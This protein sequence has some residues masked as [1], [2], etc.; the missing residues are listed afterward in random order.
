MRNILL[1]AACLAVLIGSAHATGS[2][3]NSNGPTDIDITL[4]GGDNKATNTTTTTVYGDTNKLTSDVDVNNKTNIDITNRSSS[5]SNSK[6]NSDADSYSRS[7]SDSSSKAYGGNAKSSSRTGDSNA[8]N[9]VTFTSPNDITVR[10]APT[11]N[12]VALAAGTNPCVM[13]FSASAST[14][15]IGGNVAKTYADNNCQLRAWYTLFTA[16]GDN[17]TALALACQDDRVALARRKAGKSCPGDAPAITSS[18][19]IEALPAH[20]A[21][22]V[23]H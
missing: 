11:I 10:N 12:G 7:N 17:E 4:T 1:T 3:S 6:S 14:I 9:N 23:G 22:D 18:G 16:T 15:G 13:S 5:D 8:Q 20:V 2:P 19:E 21:V